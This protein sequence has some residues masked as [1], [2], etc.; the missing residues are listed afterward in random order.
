M[1]VMNRD[2]ASAR[3][4]RNPSAQ[5][6][7]NPGGKSCF[8]DAEQKPQPIE[9]EG[10]SD[11]HHGS[12][13]ESPRDHDACDPEPRPDPGENQVAR[14]LECRVPDEEDAGAEAVDRRAE[15]EIVIHLERSESDID[16]IEKRDD[17]K[18]KEK[19]DQPVAHRPQ[20]RT[21]ERG[22]GTAGYRRI[23]SQRSTFC[24]RNREPFGHRESLPDPGR[25]QALTM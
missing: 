15:T 14:N 5:I 23:A 19:R 24:P 12:G 10:P 11:E 3:R 25:R 17:V 2:S 13:D 20:R 21:F 18:K 22:F 7:N 8:R 1:A 9:A 16:A 4:S 6:E